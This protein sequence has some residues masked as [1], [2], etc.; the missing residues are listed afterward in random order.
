MKKYIIICLALTLLSSFNV[1]AQAF[2][3]GTINS[4][5][6]I[7]LGIYGTSQTS[8]TG[9]TVDLNGL[10]L[11]ILPETTRDTTDGAASKIIPISF[12]YGVSDKIG[13]GL[14]LTLSNYFIDKEDK[15]FLNSVKGFDFG[16]KGYYHIVSTDKYDL[17]VGVGL[18]MS[19]INW[20]F[21]RVV[22]LNSGFIT[23]ESEAK[24]NGMYWN[25]E[26]K[27]KFFF[28]ENVGVFVS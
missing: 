5:L 19:K 1:N 20:K 22:D 8:T 25:L 11:V 6:G 26:V 14:D 27:H 9:L 21:N 4:D 23:E 2:Q 13:L 15:E 28:S 17:S 10:P 24:G 16:L 7:G 12:E 3:K 18:G